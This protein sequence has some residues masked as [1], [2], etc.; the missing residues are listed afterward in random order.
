M[1]KTRCTVFLQKTYIALELKY[2]CVCQ[3]FLKFI[4]NLLEIYECIWKRK[5]KKPLKFEGMKSYG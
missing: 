1:T 5:M 2:I 3:I 4:G